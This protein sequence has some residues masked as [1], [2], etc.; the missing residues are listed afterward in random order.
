M[1]RCLRQYLLWSLNYSAPPPETLVF[2]VFS[3]I[4]ISFFSSFD[5]ISLLKKIYLFSRARSR[6]ALAIASKTNIF[7]LNCSVSSSFSLSLYLFVTIAKT[8]RERGRKKLF[9]YLKCADCFFSCTC[10]AL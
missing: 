5:F 2:T 3:I 1:A 7:S 6:P 10:L 4:L 8:A 9:S